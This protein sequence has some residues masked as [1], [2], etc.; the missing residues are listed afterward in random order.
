MKDVLEGCM[1]SRMSGGRKCIGILEPELK[2][3]ERE[4]EREAGGARVGRR[5]IE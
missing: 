3:G 2:E 4:R 1:E 5:L